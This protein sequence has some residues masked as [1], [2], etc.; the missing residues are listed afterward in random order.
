MSFCLEES[1][2]QRIESLFTS[3]SFSLPQDFKTRMTKSINVLHF[4]IYGVRAKK[5]KNC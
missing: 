2:Y 4:G 5:L 3:S 1:T